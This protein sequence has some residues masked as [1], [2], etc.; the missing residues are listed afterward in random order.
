MGTDQT[1]RGHERQIHEAGTETMDE[2]APEYSEANRESHKRGA[3][4]KPVAVSGTGGV[5]HYNEEAKNGIAHDVVNNEQCSLPISLLV[6]QPRAA[7]RA[8]KRMTMPRS[9]TNFVS[10]VSQGI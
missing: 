7:I 3:L 4:V 9:S 10:C 5:V 8:V 1:T 2:S 6:R